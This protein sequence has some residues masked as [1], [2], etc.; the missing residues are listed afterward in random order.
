MAKRNKVLITTFLALVLL[1]C[2]Q[3]KFN[4]KGK[5][6]SPAKDRNELYNEL[7]QQCEGLGFPPG[8]RKRESSDLIGGDGGVYSI[9]YGSTANSSQVKSFYSEQLLLQGWSLSETPT[10]NIFNWYTTRNLFYNKGEYRI[11]ITF[12]YEDAPLKEWTVYVECSW[13][14]GRN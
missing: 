10:I 8:F 12:E 11:H 4:L 2:S 3:C 5:N 1:T 7:K 9:V 13:E 14:K 6:N